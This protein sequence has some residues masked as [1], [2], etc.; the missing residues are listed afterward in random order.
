MLFTPSKVNCLELFKWLHT[1]QISDVRLLR[2]PHWA[3]E[4]LEASFQCPIKLFKSL[5]VIAAKHNNMKFSLLLR[6]SS[7]E[8]SFHGANELCH[9][10]LTKNFPASSSGVYASS[11]NRNTQWNYLDTSR[12]TRVVYIMKNCVRR[13]QSFNN[14][15]NKS[16]IAAQRTWRQSHRI[17]SDF[18][19]WRNNN[20]SKASQLSSFNSGSSS[21]RWCEKSLLTHFLCLNCFPYFFFCCSS[22]SLTCSLGRGKS[23]W[24]VANFRVVCRLSHLIWMLFNMTSFHVSDWIGVTEWE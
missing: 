15:N 20:K 21:R 11:S 14:N 7:W 2:P 17:K 19:L 18:N 12:A 4:N 1:M 22:S 10:V 8:S 3:W 6:R 5:K 13:V 16:K 9:D 24:E 23:R